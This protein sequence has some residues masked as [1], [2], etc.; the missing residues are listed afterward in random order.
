MDA[1]RSGVI[2]LAAFAQVCSELQM[3][4]YED[5]LATLTDAAVE[6]HSLCPPPPPLVPPPASTPT[7][8]ESQEQPLA[9]EGQGS[10]LAAP[11]EGDGPQQG[12]GGS[13]GAG[14]DYA[15]FLSLVLGAEEGEA[16]ADHQGWLGCLL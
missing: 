5:L 1:D 4:E 9:A 16:T 10:A 7:R 15:T 13:G 8:A 14:L 2:S 11:G 12:G 3:G 6:E